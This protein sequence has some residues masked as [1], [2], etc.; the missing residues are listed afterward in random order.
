MPLGVAFMKAVMDAELPEVDSQIFAYPKNLKKAI[1]TAPPDVLMLTNYVWNERLTM[2]FAAYAKEKNPHCLTVVG[3]PN[4]PIEV[5]RKIDFV[6]AR[7]QIDVYAL[8]EGD[9]Y[10]SEVIRR[11]MASHGDRRSFLENDLH[12]SVY[13]KNSEKYVA[14]AIR[15]RSRNLGDIPS[16]WLTGVL[17][18]F[19]D[20]KLTPLIET[21]RGC[22]FTCTFCVQGTKWY[23]KVNYF[24]LDRI[25]QE[26]FYIAAKIDEKCPEQ[27]MIRIADPNFGMFKRDIEIASYFGETQ[28]RF[29]YPLMIDATTGKNQAEN[30]IAS[31]EQANGALAM[32]Q[33]VQSLDETVLREIK[34][35]N[36]KLE[37]YQDIQVYVQGRGLRSS[38]DLILGLPGETLESHISTLKKTINSGTHKLNNFQGM[39]LKGSELETQA[40]RMNYQFTTKFRLIPKTFGVYNGQH[41]FDIDE[42]VVST[43][44]LAFEEYLVARTYHF[45]ISVFWNESRFSSLV[46]LLEILGYQKWDFIQALYDNLDISNQVC[47]DLAASFREETSAEL[48]DSPEALVAFYSRPDNFEKACSSVIGDNLIYKY[49][50]LSSFWYWDEICGLAFASVRRVIGS[51]VD[52]PPAFWKDWQKYTVN[53]YAHGRTVEAVLGTNSETFLFDIKAWLD[54]L[55]P[56]RIGEFRF[57]VP[58]EIT[59]EL[60]ADNRKHLGGAIKIWDYELKSMPMIVR[61]IHNDWRIKKVHTNSLVTA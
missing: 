2:E 11:W 49:R 30:I 9:F 51:K 12:S 10:A 33:A 7:P 1:D 35:K 14:T 20:G 42:I 37:T 40:S 6:R 48:F 50:A 41:V 32:Y 47:S 17:D 27:K 54:T 24:D 15:P 13:R 60:D 56:N 57:A 58:R 3:G 36:I 46:E 59:F 43:N 4:I 19:F 18:K 61:R 38:S 26:I 53:R 16:P 25:R 52:I 29:D 39:L 31:I 23:T 55:D 28:K 22:P 44:T 5:E 8:G 34:R 21:N 45:I